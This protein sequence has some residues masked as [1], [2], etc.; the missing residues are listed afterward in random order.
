M[1]VNIQ[2]KFKHILTSSIPNPNCE[3]SLLRKPLCV[4]T[5]MRASGRFASHFRKRN[6]S[7][8]HLVGT[9]H[10]DSVRILRGKG[11]GGTV[12]AGLAKL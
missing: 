4:T 5:A 10:R 9:A 11:G 3:N 1:A 8:H 2:T 12:P 7:I 6:L